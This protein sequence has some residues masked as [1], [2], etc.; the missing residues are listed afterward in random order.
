MSYGSCG[1]AFWCLEDREPQKSDTEIY[2]VVQSFDLNVT[3]L[4]SLLLSK[5][6]FN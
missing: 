3:V 5:I 1:H 4:G 2:T 6:I